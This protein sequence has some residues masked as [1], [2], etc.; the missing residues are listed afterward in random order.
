MVEKSQDE[1]LA[2]QV[3]VW[4]R[5]APVYQQEIDKRFGP[6]VEAVLDRADLRPWQA[7][8]DLGTGTGAVAFAAA[9]QV[10]AGGRVTAVDISPE[11]LATARAGAEARA[12]T[13][14]DFAEGR[15]EA[16]PVSS[17][18][19]DAVLASLS[20]MYVIDRAATAKE[21]ARVLRSS[22]RFI[23]AVW[24]GADQADIV[25]FQQLAGSFA[26]KPPVEGVG[27]GALADPTPFLEQLSDA[28]LE[29]HVEAETTGFHFANFA[30]AWEALAA[31][32]TAAL[33]PVIQDQAKSAVRDRMWAGGDGPRE[34]RNRTQFI[35]ATRPD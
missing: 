13:N 14:I 4:N 28:G 19:Q 9:S 7:V 2:W 21:V 25:Q 24:A 5:M 6:V 3:G 35:I 8:L 23:G 33:E 12:L 26:P 30:A 1:G 27:P 22:G 16:I 32:T 29:A 34:F 17:H 18:S 10:G 20:L 15:G 31:V 11:M